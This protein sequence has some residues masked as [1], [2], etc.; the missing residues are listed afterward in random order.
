LLLLRYGEKILRMRTN[1][2]EK[3]YHACAQR[4]IGCFLFLYVRI[5]CYYYG[6]E[7]KVSRM[8]TKEKWVF[9]VFCVYSL[10]LFFVFVFLCLFS[11]FVSLRLFSVFIFCEVIFCVYFLRF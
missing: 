10:R 9:F 3:K 11:A 4:K 8:R 7:K 6:T 5:V 1:G 2:T